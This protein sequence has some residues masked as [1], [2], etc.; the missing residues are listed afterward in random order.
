MA[1]PGSR[2]GVTLIELLVALAISGLA[3]LGGLALLD[4]V[5]DGDARIATNSLRDARVA[6]GD[7]VLRLLLADARSTTDTADRFRGDERN[8]SFLTLCET[9]S[10]WSEPCRALLSIDSVGDSSRI[11]AQD[12]RG[13]RQIVRE[14]RGSTVFRYLDLSAAKDSTWIGRWST[15]IALPGA[16]AVISSRDTTVLPMGSVHE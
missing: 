2:R 16:I 5:Q 15:S 12:D 6:N 9:A 14:V 1:A 3:L 10:G 13:D 7:R 8:A 4:Q 11:I